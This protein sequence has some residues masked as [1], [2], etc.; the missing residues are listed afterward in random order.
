[1]LSLAI[2]SLPILSC[3]KAAGEASPTERARAQIESK[4]RKFFVMLSIPCFALLAASRH[5]D[6]VDHSTF[7]T[8][9][10]LTVVYKSP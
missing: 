9:R 4:A 7:V 3:A 5:F 8:N 6:F 1:M 2:P 10:D